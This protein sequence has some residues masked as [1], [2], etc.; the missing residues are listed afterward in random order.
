MTRGR[1]VPMVDALER[2]TGRIRFSQDAAVPG[3]LHAAV[4]RSTQP[5]AR[6]RRIDTSAAVAVPGVV[7]V[8]TAAD[9]AR[10]PG[11]R[12]VYGPQIEDQPI[13]AIDRVRYV[14]DMVA[15]VAAETPR[16]AREAASRIV[17]EYEPLPAVFDPVEAMQPGAP[18]VHELRPDEPLR[19]HAVYF[20]LRPLFGTNCCNHFRLYT[21]D[22]ERGFAEA[23]L[24]LEE[25]FRVPAAQHVA[26]EPHAAL[27]YWEDG[28]LVVIS[29]T[30]TPFNTRQ[31]LAQIFGL[32]AERVRI[33]VPP[34]GGSFGCKVFPRIEPQVAV[35][36]Y[37]TGRPVKLVLDRYEEFLT[38]TRHATVVTIRLGLTRDGRIT[39]KRV[40]AYW[41]TGAYADCGPDV[42]RKG[43][44]GSV[45]PYRIPHVAVDSYC[46][47]TNLP[48]AGAFRGY[49]VTEIVWASERMMDI[50]ADA[51]GLDPLEFRLRNL[52]AD[53]DEFAT[54][55]TLHDVHFRECLEAAARAIAWH[56]EP[57][58][59]PDGRVRAKGLAV[60]MKGMTTP[61]R[62]EAAVAVD[63]DGRVTVY[64]STVE[65]GQG[66]RTV[67]AQ[68]AAE[69]LGLPYTAV[70]LVDP[71]T[72]RT[73]FDNRT[74]S[75]R[76]TY[77]MGNAV[78]RAARQLADRLRALAAERL[79]AA[80]ED[81]ELVPG[82]VCVRGAPER[83]IGWGE[84]VAGLGRDELREHAE[85]H[86]EGGLDETGHGIASSHW[87]QGA[88]G[89]EVEVDL[90]TGQVNVVRLHAAVYAG[91][92]VNTLTAALQNEGSM[93]MGL[94][95]ALFEE[96]IY[97]QGQP[98]TT[99]LSD[100]LVPSF[101]DLPAQLSHDLLEYPGAEVH[102]VGETALPPV[103]AAIGNAVA[104][105][106]G[107]RLTEL[108][109]TPERV[110]RAIRGTSEEGR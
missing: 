15:L 39:A 21:G 18:L 71:D 44:F 25:T 33:V 59:L 95:S 93:I 52:L 1:A 108:P 26:M 31:I 109:L 28:R 23:D 45:G 65:L 78:R 48:P 24:V 51:L 32:P 80:P 105:A 63:R 41:S 94:G 4:V 88:A 107:A 85:F 8:V 3:M 55:E 81:L 13:L 19:G 6:I 58:V 75:S 97:E 61:S 54:G 14:G 5:H 84:L 11:I 9:L 27:A 46:V 99:N 37:L 35:L 10:I 66:A 100:Y 92:V 17:V 49:A 42:A 56:P 43:G 64:S 83:C 89:A 47:Y 76:S 36:S 67:L 40:E 73:P 72:D 38:L 62:S 2:V 53:G 101:L 104:R 20:G 90:E 29:G 34:M 60:V 103:P 30:Q 82:A 110:L 68:L 74:T 98:L 91:E 69:P 106:T 12:P 22:I 87:H 16:A 7:A 86:N 50:A 79:E 57:T 96:L 77:M 102:G 70:Q